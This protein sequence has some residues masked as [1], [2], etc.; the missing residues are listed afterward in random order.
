MSASPV[1]RPVSAL[2]TALLLLLAAPAS[3]F[4]TSVFYKLSTDFR[5]PGMQL[6][7]ANG[8][9]MNNFSHLAPA[10]NYSGQYW[11]E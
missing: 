7:I 8:G 5:G 9:A 2:A 11:P 10:G 1:S 4:D 3:A 6:D